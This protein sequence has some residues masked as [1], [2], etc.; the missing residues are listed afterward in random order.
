M[1]SLEDK[2]GIENPIDL[3]MLLKH[4]THLNLWD[5]QYSQSKVRVV[6]VSILRSFL[7]SICTFFRKSCKV[8]AKHIKITNIILHK[9]RG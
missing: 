4:T 2:I 9:K 1:R 3:S 5:L 7:K 6:R 8:E